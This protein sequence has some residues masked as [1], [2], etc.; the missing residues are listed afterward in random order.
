M[1]KEKGF[2]LIELL[3]VIVI[4]AI[5]M[6]IAVPKIL[7]VI[8]N[9]KESAAKSSAGLYID[10]INKNNSLAE[11]DEQ[12][13]IIGDGEKNIKLLDV[14]VKGEKPT[15]GLVTI[16]Q[17]KVVAAD[18]CVNGFH[19]NYSGS[20]YNIVDDCLDGEINTGNIVSS[21]LLNYVKEKN[22]K[23][24][25]IVSVEVSDELYTIHTYNY[26]T[27]QIWSS[28]MIFGNENDAANENEDA[29]NMI[30]VKVN[31]DLT[32]N[33]GVNVSTYANKNGYGGPKGL[34]IYVT[35]TLT[36]NGT[37]SMT[38][39]GAKAE[40]QNVYLFK[41]PDGSYEYVP[42]YG[43]LGGEAITSNKSLA[44]NN[45]NNGENRKTG[46]GGSG[47]TCNQ[48][49]GAPTK[50]SGAGSNGTS[51]S[52]GTGGASIFG[53]VSGIV[54]PSEQNGGQG[55]SA[56]VNSSYN[57]YVMGGGAGNP[58]GFGKLGSSYNSLYDGQNGT[59]G[60]LVIYSN[61][62]LNNGKIESNGSKGGG[63]QTEDTVGGAGSGAGSI[64]IFY[65]NNYFSNGTI[66]AQGGS[67]GPG[68][69][70]SGKG[71]NGSITIG[72]VKDNIFKAN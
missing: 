13:K 52:G 2:T 23:N 16:K 19:V 70:V 62:I 66:E 6:V 32:I 8:E 18:L 45:G 58:G 60:L 4:L 48:T 3:A 71:G 5:L 67:S 1:K 53:N 14:K 31:G 21:S 38:S 12:Y 49:S 15:S 65:T 43:A 42:K 51:Y 7:N 46:G 41:N 34:L 44:G 59:G 64:N 29:K 56:T 68:I 54:E 37:I 40:G 28:D 10:A 36:N 9:S 63:T 24:N 47:A 57:G 50:T 35:G 22:L 30:L 39:R 33:E 61:N 17:K 26:N 72:S 20:K 69:K 27:S 25:S 55:G 11:I